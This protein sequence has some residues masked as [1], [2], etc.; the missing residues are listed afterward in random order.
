[1]MARLR[2]P[3]P[4]ARVA[5]GSL[6]NALCSLVIAL[7]QLA[8]IPLLTQAW[9]VETFGLWVMMIALPTYIA[10]ADFG[11]MA[12]AQVQMTAHLSKG[13]AGAARAVLRTACLSASAFGAIIALVALGAIAAFLPVPAALEAGA[14]LGALGAVFAYGVVILFSQGLKVALRAHGHAAS[15]SLHSAFAYLVEGVAVVLVAWAGLGVMVAAGALL[16]A[17]VVTTAALIPLLSRLAPWAGLRPLRIERHQL[18]ALARPSAGALALT[19]VGAVGV[20]GAVLALGAVAGPAIVAIYAT[21]RTLTR[22]P[23]QVAG[24]VLRPSLPEL[25]RAAT[26]QDRRL[27]R[28]LLRLNLAVA[29]AVSL[30]AIVILFLFG[31]A[32]LG[33]ISGGRIA[34]IAG[35]IGILS[36]V[37]GVNALTTGLASPLVATNAQAGFAYLYLALSLG[38]VA[39]I[40]VIGQDHARHLALALLAVELAVLA[41]VIWMWRRKAGQQ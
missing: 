12:A 40:F 21:S 37:M 35:L 29:L 5:R 28:G 33:L 26:Q 11:L 24:F 30:P 8:H 34:P 41:R 25:T 3:S 32:L 22:L 2:G 23:L 13:E 7:V 16:A 14:F 20:Q 17:R 39:S 19:L 1:M 36:L 4:Q 9:G 10:L 6:A 15:D 31:D 18:R 27:L 38:A